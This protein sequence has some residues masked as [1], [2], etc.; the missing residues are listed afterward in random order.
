[1]RVLDKECAFF[2]FV[3]PVPS[4]SPWAYGY[5]RKGHRYILFW[6][7]VREN[8]KCLPGALQPAIATESNHVALQWKA[9]FCKRPI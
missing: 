1:M 3:S 7:R 6:T 8:R 9:R 2:K 5:W 4:K